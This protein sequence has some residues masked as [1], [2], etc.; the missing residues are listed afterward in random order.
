MNW[1]LTTKVMPRWMGVIA[2]LVAFTLLLGIGQQSL[3]IELLIQSWV[4]LVSA[5]ILV[6]H[7]RS[8]ARAQQVAA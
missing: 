6:N 8:P 5:Y 1:K 4:I 3:W 2:L 7:F